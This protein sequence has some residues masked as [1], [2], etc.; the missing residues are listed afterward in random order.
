MLKLLVIIFLILPFSRANPPQVEQNPD[1]ES[2]PCGYS[3][4]KIFIGAAAGTAL[5]VSA[6]VATPVFLSYVGFSA[7]G[8]VGGSI[9]AAAQ[10]TIGNVAA[11]GIF[12]TLQSVGAVGG[13][14]V[15]AAGATTVTATAAG[16]ATGA[17][18]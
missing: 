13:L 6:V 17:A 3:W 12:A 16:A 8:V 11:G 1:H 14:S 5:G 15:T 10:S 9:A 18:L 2:G 4:K 7:S